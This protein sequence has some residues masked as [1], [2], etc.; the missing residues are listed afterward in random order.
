MLLVF[1]QPMGSYSVGEFRHS[2][3]IYFAYALVIYM[4]LPMCAP[5]P[6]QESV[7]TTASSASLLAMPL[8][9]AKFGAQEKTSKHLPVYHGLWSLMRY[10]VNLFCLS[11]WLANK[12][13][14][15]LCFLGG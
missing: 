11:T 6:T 10:Q 2:N 13:S 3:V 1:S 4:T 12:L 14:F 7:E 9:S 5:V 15:E 8:I